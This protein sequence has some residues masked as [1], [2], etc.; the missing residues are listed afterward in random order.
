MVY[1]SENRK[2]VEDSVKFDVHCIHA[3]GDDGKHDTA[4]SVANMEAV[5]ERM[6]RL[7]WLKPGP[8]GEPP[9]LFLQSDG[10]VKEYKSAPWGESLKLSLVKFD[11]TPKY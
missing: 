5:L 7:K 11:Q 8:N 1:V 10:S 3:L 9:R 2:R 6:K 4:T